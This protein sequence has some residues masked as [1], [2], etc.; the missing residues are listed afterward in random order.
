MKYGFDVLQ[1]KSWGIKAGE[2]GDDRSYA[3][4]LAYKTTRR[5]IQDRLQKL[6]IITS[7]GKSVSPKILY[8]KV[9]LLKVKISRK[10]F[11]L[12]LE[13][14]EE[15][16]VPPEL[17][18][19]QLPINYRFYDSILNNCQQ[20]VSKETKE[21]FKFKNK[22]KFQFMRNEDF[23]QRLLEKLGILEATNADAEAGKMTFKHKVVNKKELNQINHHIN[24]HT[25]ALQRS[26][27]LVIDEDIH[28]IQ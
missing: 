23:K 1:M 17:A 13:Q 21:F 9:A 5:F 6:R 26:N 27:Y 15:V 19:N 11:I 4:Y 2:N 20:M 28:R 16:Y 7:M 8:I 12:D 24:T 18:Q 14:G 3:Q 25:M 10:L 22:F